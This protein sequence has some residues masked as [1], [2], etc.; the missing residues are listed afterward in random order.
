MWSCNSATLP[1]LSAGGVGHGNP[2]AVGNSGEGN[3]AGGGGGGGCVSAAVVVRGSTVGIGD[4]RGGAD[5]DK[6]SKPE[7]GKTLECSLKN[8]A[9]MYAPQAWAK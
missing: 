9:M 8:F 7:R 3:V 4:T 6:V 1:M 5:C 2:A